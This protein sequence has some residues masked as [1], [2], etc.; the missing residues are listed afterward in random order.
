MITPSFLHAEPAGVSPRPCSLLVTVFPLSYNLLST[1]G[2]RRA[3]TIKEPVV[4]TEAQ[5][6]PD[7]LS[8]R[9]AVLCC[10]GWV[11]WGG[12]DGVGVGKALLL[13]EDLQESIWIILSW[14]EVRA[15]V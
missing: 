4:S 10:V 2:S 11:E 9:C 6:S 1:N 5:G 7:S 13:K 12:R 8:T 3:L 15:P 14:W